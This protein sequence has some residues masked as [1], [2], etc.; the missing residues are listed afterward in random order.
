MRVALITVL[1][2]CTTAPVHA[3]PPVAVTSLDGYVLDARGPVANA[4]L[5]LLSV[6]AHACPCTAGDAAT[7]SSMNALPD[8]QCPAALAMWRDQLD[9]CD[10]PAPLATARTG[11]GGHAVVPILERA[12]MVVATTPTGERWLRMPAMQAPIA[13]ELAK[14]V[15]P[16]VTID[17]RDAGLHGALM[18]PDGHC[19]RLVR[20]RTGFVAERPVPA[21][22]GDLDDATLVFASPDAG[23][24]KSMCGP[25]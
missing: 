5:R 11:A 8:C 13:L 10:P 23:R 24:T 16:H 21:P 19:T 4:E 18:F 7:E 12:T 6:P 20:D 17:V 3:P 1:A 25:V 15:V 22:V 2:A 9:Q 14:L